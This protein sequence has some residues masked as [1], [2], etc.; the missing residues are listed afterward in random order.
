MSSRRVERVSESVREAI[1]EM[2]VSEVKDPRIGFVTITGAAISDD[3]RHARVL[4]SCIGD[5]NARDRTLAGLRSASGFMKTQL[6]RRLKL[7]YAPEI[8]FQFDPTI[9][10][11]ERLAALLRDARKDEEPEG[12]S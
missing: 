9:A 8:I 2:L 6:M 3:L 10:E 4:F 11:A 1:A 12:E 7:R 5:Q